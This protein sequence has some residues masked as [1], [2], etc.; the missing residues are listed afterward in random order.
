MLGCPCQDHAHAVTLTVYAQHADALCCMSQVRQ[1]LQLRPLGTGNA[2]LAAAGGAA[3][4]RL[5]QVYQPLADDEDAQAVLPEVGGGQD[6]LAQQL[7][8]AAGRQRQAQQQERGGDGEGNLVEHLPPANGGEDVFTLL[9]MYSISPSL[10]RECE[11]V[12]S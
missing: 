7:A 2:G 12:R 5:P 3:Q 1:R 4:V 8:R 11:G 10:V 6:V 9:K